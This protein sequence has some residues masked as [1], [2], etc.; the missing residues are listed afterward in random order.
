MSQTGSPF[1]IFEELIFPLTLD[2]LLSQIRAHYQEQIQ[3]NGIE[4]REEQKI[5]IG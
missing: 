1:M 3:A 4:I 5:S 2:E